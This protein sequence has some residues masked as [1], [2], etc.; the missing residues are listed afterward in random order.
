M[1]DIRTR[2]QAISREDLNESERRRRYCHVLGWTL[3]TGSP[4]TLR[5]TETGRL[6]TKGWGPDVCGYIAGY[7][8]ALLDHRLPDRPEHY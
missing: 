2:L 1:T 6:I 5:E 7:V 4:H 3:D 8:A